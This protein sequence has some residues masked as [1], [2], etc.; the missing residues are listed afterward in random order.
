MDIIVERERGDDSVL[1]CPDKITPGVLN[2]ACYTLTEKWTHEG[3]LS[4]I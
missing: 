1:L 2:S 3:A 4:R